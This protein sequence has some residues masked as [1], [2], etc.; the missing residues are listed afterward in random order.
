[1][2]WNLLAEH[3]G[4]GFSTQYCSGGRQIIGLVETT[5]MNIRLVVFLLF[6][7]SRVSISAIFNQKVE[8]ENS[9]FSYS[10]KTYEKVVGRFQYQSFSSEN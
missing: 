5:I 7:C 10:K 6:C 8:L 4:M 3:G 2:F 1:M 9:L